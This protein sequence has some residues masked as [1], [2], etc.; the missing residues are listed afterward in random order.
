MLNDFIPELFHKVKIID[1]MR[2]TKCYFPQGYNQSP[3]KRCVKCKDPYFLFRFNKG[4]KSRAPVFL[5][6][7]KD[8]LTVDRPFFADTPKDG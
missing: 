4:S 1:Q 7:I 8:T 3:V 5:V 2:F 6:I